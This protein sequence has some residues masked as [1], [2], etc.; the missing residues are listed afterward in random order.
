MPRSL[1]GKR[2]LI[3][4]GD[5]PNLRLFT[6]L[7]LAAGGE[8]ESVASAEE[9]LTVL[10]PD[11]LPNVVLVDLVLPRMSAFALVSQLRA[12]P[13]G[14]EITYVAV[15]AVGGPESERAA[16]AAGFAVMLTK[17]IDTDSFARTIARA[18]EEG[19]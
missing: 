17:P 16:K 14:G 7:A 4:D 18:M 11:R 19:P 10:A 15:S 6:A 8:V 12:E 13:W 3:V 9:A 1:H 5:A 2:V